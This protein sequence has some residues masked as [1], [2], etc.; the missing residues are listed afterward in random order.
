LVTFFLAKQKKV[1]SCR[2]TPG[3]VDFDVGLRD[4]AANPTYNPS[5]TV[6]IAS[7]LRYHAPIKFLQRSPSPLMTSD[8]SLDPHPSPEHATLQKCKEAAAASPSPAKRAL[9]LLVCLALG[10]TIG[11]I[12]QSITSQSMWFL[13]VPVCI[14]IGWL[15]VANPDECVAP[16]C[17]IRQD[18]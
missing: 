10:I 7:L 13:A 2:A 9:L 15:F 12:G 5:S 18:D 4:E 17:S 6:R 14:A 11:F 8:N 3:G 16:Q 1:T